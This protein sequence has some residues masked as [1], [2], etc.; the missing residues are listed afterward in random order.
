MMG[1]FPLLKEIASEKRKTF[2]STG[3]CE[4]KEIDDV[5]E[6]FKKRKM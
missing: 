2:I 1:N 3:M 4:L 5:V 6:I